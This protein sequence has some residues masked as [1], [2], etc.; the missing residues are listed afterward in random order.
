[1][2]HKV[3]GLQFLATCMLVVVNLVFS[4][5]MTELLQDVLPTVVI[6]TIAL[7]ITTIWNFY[8]YRTRI[9]KG[10]SELAG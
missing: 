7:G 5:L 1:M 8:I 6:R 3:I 2:H 10:A 4:L 9:F